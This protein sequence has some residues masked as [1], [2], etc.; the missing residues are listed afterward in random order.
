MLWAYF[1]IFF[2]YKSREMYNIF[3]N[4]L[5]PER[6]KKHLFDDLWKNTY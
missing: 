5:F 2:D 4:D 3:E 1:K 6:L